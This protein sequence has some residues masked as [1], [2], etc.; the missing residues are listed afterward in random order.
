MAM[1]PARLILKVD[2]H[3]NAHDGMRCVV[4]V[5]KP[6]SREV[7]S[8]SLSDLN[9]GELTRVC[10]Y[11]GLNHKSYPTATEKLA[12]IQQ[13]VWTVDYTPHA[14]VPKP[15]RA[16]QTPPPIVV[17]QGL[18]QEWREAVEE[19]EREDDEREED[20]RDEKVTVVLATVDET[21]ENGPGSAVS[22]AMATLMAAMAPKVDEEKLTATITRQV[23]EA[24]DSKLREIDAVPVRVT[25]VMPDREQDLPTLHHKDLPEVIQVIGAGVA[26][27]LSGP[28]GTGKSTIIE[29]AAKTLGMDF[30]PMSCDPSM[31]RSALFG[32]IDAGGKYHST[33]FR[34]AY[35]KGGMFSLDE[36]DNGHPSILA[37]LNQAL[38]NGHC[39]FPDGVITKHVG[40]MFSATANTWGLGATAEYVG[41]NPVDAATLDRFPAKL[42]I[43]YDA[44]MERQAALTYATDDTHSTI[45]EWIDTVQGI[46]RRAA[47]D[48]VRI[49]I[50]PRA[51]I[52]GAR[53]IAAGIQ[54]ARV[55]ELTVFAGVSKDV[56]EK[57]AA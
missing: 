45:S 46:R 52:A 56:R 20:E 50:T 42:F 26:P 25:V 3:L 7:Q 13:A 48:N 39:A 36:I 34:D 8:V 28:A 35:E 12:A 37:G 54:V 19:D 31:M 2:R 41:R 51:T 38:A 32:F 29:Q 14:F 18:E 55:L 43:D 16:R 17:E 53:L 40:F 57:V 49:L 10:A 23:F 15:A 27:F 5:R 11:L 33:P 24:I 9:G 22:D 1:P 21:A 6:E 4:E 30:Y 44:K 47:K